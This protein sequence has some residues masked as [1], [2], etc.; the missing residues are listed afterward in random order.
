MPKLKSST[1]EADHR[2]QCVGLVPIFATLPET[3]RSQV[4]EVARTRH[5]QRQEMIYVPGDRSG[6]HLVHRG[7]VKVFRVT[8]SRAEQ[9]IRIL[10]PGEFLG[11]TALLLAAEASDCAM[12]IQPIEVCSISQE[13]IRE[14]LEGHP[15]VA[16]DLLQS[17]SER[18]HV[19]EEQLSSMSGLPVAERLAQ[20]LLELAVAAED[21]SFRLPSTKKDLA[22]YLGT[23]ADAEPATR[24]DA[25]SAAHPDRTWPRGGDSR[26]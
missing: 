14:L 7:Q 25:G 26:A 23:T 22:A 10:G 4:A 18:L 15:D 3:E 5:Y 17:V 11:K 24:H 20:H 2:L 13:G 6:L 9:L 19:A 1:V 16:L 21:T 8:E 12:A